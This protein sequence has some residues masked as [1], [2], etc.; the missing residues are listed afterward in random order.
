MHTPTTVQALFDDPAYEATVI[1]PAHATTETR[2]LG[3]TCDSRHVQPGWL[4]AAWAG[5]R[6]DGRTFVDQAV[7][8]GAAVVV[9]DDDARGRSI[10]QQLEQRGVVTVLVQRDARWVI[11]KAAAQW[12]GLPATQMRMIGITG[13]NGK[14]TTSY[15]IEG[16]LAAAGYH[17][18]VIGT[19][20]AH[21]GAT[22]VDFG[23]TTPDAIALQSLLSTM[24]AGG[25]DAVAMEVSSHA[26][27][28]ERVAGVDYDVGV[29]SNLTRDHLDYHGTLE[30]YTH[31]KGRL[32]LERIK[33]GGW[34]VLNVDDPI[35]GPWVQ[36]HGDD[37][38]ARDVRVLPVALSQTIG[39][40]SDRTGI[41]LRVRGADA[42]HNAWMIH[43]PLV[44]TFNAEN[45]LTAVGVGM[46]LGLSH[47]VIQRGLAAVTRVPGRLDRITC[48]Q[49][50]GSQAPIPLI[51]V[52]Y[53][54]TPDAL[55][56][57]LTT[58]RALTP[59]KLLCVFGCG[60]DRDSGKRAPMG[61]IAAEHAD[62]SIL[63][64]DNPRTEDPAVIAAAVEL[65]LRDG[66][67]ACMEQPI[68]GQRGY[69]VE[70]DRAQAIARAVAMAGPEDGVVI[71]GKGH[72]TYQIIGTEKRHFDD[73]EVAQYALHQW[74]TDHLSSS[75]T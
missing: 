12:Y 29:W 34:A 64:N 33:P 43:S 11:A 46:A 1:T 2:I 17:P 10:A 6:T 35:I 41:H 28:Q 50:T 32:F 21:Y 53:A 24:R 71:A 18:G 57:V 14:T 63:T 59:G 74:V 39:W 7:Q 55:H 51:A 19:L 13:T 70:L 54:H 3:M 60:G 36:K 27:D 42:E 5:A 67:A 48:S 62:W 61:R 8:L 23:L 20:G 16:V 25:C 58:V 52:D 69:C 31:A 40:A 45:V 37:L 22:H 73:R 9:L 65:G 72:E 68:Q 4:F 44:G 15:L 38:A 30:A 47:D 56:K 26:L 75:S 66:G 49:S